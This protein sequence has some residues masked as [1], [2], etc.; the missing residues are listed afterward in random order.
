MH[1]TTERDAPYNILTWCTGCCQLVYL[2]RISPTHTG[3]GTDWDI[4]DTASCGQW[5]DGECQLCGVSCDQGAIGLVSDLVTDDDSIRFLR[6]TP[7]EHYEGEAG[8]T[9]EV[10]HNTWNW[11]TLMCNIYNKIADNVLSSLVKTVATSEKG[12]VPMLLTAA[13]LKV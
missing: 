11:T 6:G 5:W 10:R 4:S 3:V 2:S 9:H 1:R 7:S 12:P 13:T 8:R